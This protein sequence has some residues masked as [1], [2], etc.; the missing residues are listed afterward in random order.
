MVT[1]MVFCKI[2]GRAGH[3]TP[4]MPDDAFSPTIDVLQVIVL[5]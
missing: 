1:N 3:V 4:K 5:C 2:V